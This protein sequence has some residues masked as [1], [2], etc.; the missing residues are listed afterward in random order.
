[1]TKKFALSAVNFGKSLDSLREEAAKCLMVCANCH[2]EL[3]Y[4]DVPEG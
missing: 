4:G 3:E 1:M 2:R